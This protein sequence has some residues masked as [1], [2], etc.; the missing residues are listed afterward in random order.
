MFFCFWLVFLSEYERNIFDKSFV[1]EVEDEDEQLQE[2][3]MICTG[4]E[5]TF[6]MVRLRE[7]LCCFMIM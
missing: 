5:R 7:M 3:G 2:V 6:V 1:L 4:L